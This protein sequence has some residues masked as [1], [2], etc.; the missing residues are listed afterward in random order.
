MSQKWN[1]RKNCYQAL[2]K[3]SLVQDLLLAFRINPTEKAE[4]TWSFWH[5]YAFKGQTAFICTEENTL[6]WQGN[7][8]TSLFPCL[9]FMD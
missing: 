3:A 4:E 6:L 9:V 7:S 1:V 2:T 8:L 5:I